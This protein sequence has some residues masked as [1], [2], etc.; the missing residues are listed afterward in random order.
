MQLRHRIPVAW[1]LLVHRKGRFVL[2]LLG[3]AFSVVIMFMEVGF[4]NG[5]ND[6]QARLATYLDGDVALIERGRYSLLE[7]NQ[8]NRIRMQQALGLPEVVSATPLYEGTELI[9]NPQ[10][11][12]VQAASVLA[13]PAGTH[14]LKLPELDTYAAQLAIR[15][16]VLFDRRA[17]D[18]FGPI[19]PGTQLQVPDGV[20]N[21]VGMVSMGPSIR[22]DGWVLMAEHSWINSK[23]EA[24]LVT[25][26]LLKVRPGTDIPALKQKLLKLVGE[27]VLVMTPEEL[28]VREVE[29]TADA[30]PAGGVFAI[31]LAIGFLIGMIIC[32]QILFNE[33]SDNM[34]QYAT[35]KA[36]GFSRTYLVALVLQQALLL[37]LF[38]FLPGLLGGGLLYTVI[39]HSTGILMFLSW[40]R[41]LLVFA[42]TVFM[43]IGSGLLAVQK[44]LRADPA[45]VF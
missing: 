6:S 5:I 4:Y 30:T 21:V 20:Q 25:M 18:L 17:R 35:V 9:V 10:T 44:V 19:G 24:D 7:M 33:I 26:A 39:E 28:R 3:I 27:E 32:Y 45:E 23:E 8:L 12:L 43:C 11:G 38:G 36:V 1:Y 29:F 37:S 34:P 42:L 22:T 15:G 41:S 40:P 2:S 31:G 13:F 16:N 14:P